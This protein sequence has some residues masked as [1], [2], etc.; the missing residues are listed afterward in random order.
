MKLV[1]FDGMFD[2][3]LAQYFKE[4]AGKYTEKQWEDKIPT[5][6]QRF[7]DTYIK[8]V[9]A[10][11]RGYYERMTDE[12][13]CSCLKEHVEQGVPV[14][15]FLCRELEK[16]NCPLPLVV[17]LKEEN[18]ELLT[19]AVN[20]AGAAPAAF[21]AYF[22]ILKGNADREIKDAVTDQ[23]KANADEAKENALACYREGVEKELM[24]EILS[25]TKERD[26]NV[27]E[28]LLSAFRCEEDLPMHASY[29]AAYGDARAL[30]VLLERVDR[31][32]INFLE[33]R[34]LKYAIESLGGEYTR[35]RDFSSDP[36]YREI[37]EQS[38]PPE[39]YSK[40]N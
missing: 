26:D 37:M 35:E 33:Y 8:S 4:N 23:L 11:P 6:Y 2:K 25:R 28:I 21:P 5:L 30:P 24:L 27:F 40:K 18:E 19:F 7:G 39:F 38:L 17:L 14:S 10:T 1:D 32:E 15:D 13:I 20:L 22:D 3:K 12:E 36:Y 31:D 9:G 29:L 34:E 16:R